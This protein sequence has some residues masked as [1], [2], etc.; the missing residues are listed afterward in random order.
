MTAAAMVFL[1]SGL[2]GVLR[3][4]VFQLFL[5]LGWLALPLA[6]LAVNVIGSFVIGMMIAAMQRGTGLLGLADGKAFLMIGLL[7][8]FTTF[9]AFS[10][11]VLGMAHNGQWVQTAAYVLASVLLSLLAV[12]AGFYLMRGGAA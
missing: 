8:G 7:G 5:A 11:D 4:A 6:T 12:A 2:G 10:A 9:S 3:Y 1:G